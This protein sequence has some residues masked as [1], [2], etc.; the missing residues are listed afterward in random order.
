MENALN[1]TSRFSSLKTALIKYL[2]SVIFGAVVMKI[3]IS[4]YVLNDNYLLYCSF[5]VY[6]G[7]LFFVFEKLKPKNKLRGLVYI[8]LMAFVIFL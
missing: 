6:E 8:L 2:P 4:E 1:K 5:A 3:I 7:I